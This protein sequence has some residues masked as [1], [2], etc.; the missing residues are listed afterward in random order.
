MKKLLL[1]LITAFFMTVFAGCYFKI[2]K[3]QKNLD[4]IVANDITDKDAGFG[5]DSN[6]VTIINKKGDFISLETMSKKSVG[7]ELFNIILQDLING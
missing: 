3:T 2:D 4:Y 7:R 6:K 5:K 1:I